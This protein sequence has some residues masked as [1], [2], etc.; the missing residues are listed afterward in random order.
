[1]H[2]N[3]AT[4]ISRVRQRSISDSTKIRQ[5]IEDTAFEGHWRAKGNS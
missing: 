4:R 3:D 5:T 2:G 1:L